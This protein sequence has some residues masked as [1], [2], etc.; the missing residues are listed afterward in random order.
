M[1][2]LNKMR[3]GICRAE[4]Y[5]QL[6]R[7]H[8]HQLARQ[9]E[10]MPNSIVCSSHYSKTLCSLLGKPQ[11]LCQTYTYTF[12]IICCYVQPQVSGLD[13][14]IHQLHLVTFK[15]QKKYLSSRIFN[16]QVILDKNNSINKMLKMSNSQMSN[17]NILV[18]GSHQH[19][20]LK[21]YIT[22]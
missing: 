20:F 18:R 15:R 22:I 21:L 7:I 19:K 2:I 5:S 14:Y 3:P 1:I 17:L 12:F 8:H 10:R 4:L 6:H 13:F 16:D 11:S 9:M